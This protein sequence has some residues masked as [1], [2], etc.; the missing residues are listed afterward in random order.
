MTDTLMSL[1]NEARSIYPLH[2]SAFSYC[3]LSFHLFLLTKSFQC[4][5]F[6][7]VPGRHYWSPSD[8]KSQKFCKSTRVFLISIIVFLDCGLL[9]QLF[10][11]LA[12]YTLQKIKCDVNQHVL[13]SWIGSFIVLS[14]IFSFFFTPVTCSAI[15]ALSPSLEL[16][17]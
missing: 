13:S 9:F 8:S 11:F 4:Y 17:G 6:S 5:Y 10:W 16:N 14:K 3:D 15:V 1:T 7:S 12:A 2:P